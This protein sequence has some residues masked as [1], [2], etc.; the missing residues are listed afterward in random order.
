MS[1]YVGSAPGAFHA[2]TNPSM[3][4]GRGY[5][6]RLRTLGARRAPCQV[7]RSRL[8]SRPGL[9]LLAHGVGPAHPV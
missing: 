6:A 8:Y 4:Y 7:P 5:S 1:S 9:P 2:H 3:A